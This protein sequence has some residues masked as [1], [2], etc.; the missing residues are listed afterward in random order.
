MRVFLLL[1]AL[2]APVLSGAQCLQLSGYGAD[3]LAKAIA[4]KV[5]ALEAKVPAPKA[6]PTLMF[7]TTK[8]RDPDVSAAGRE[9]AGVRQALKDAGCFDGDR[10]TRSVMRYTDTNKLAFI[11]SETD[12]LIK[13]LHERINAVGYANIDPATVSELKVR[14][15][16]YVVVVSGRTKAIREKCAFRFKL[17]AD[18]D[19]HSVG[20]REVMVGI[21]EV[22]TN[23]DLP[24]KYLEFVQDVDAR[25]IVIKSKAPTPICL[26]TVDFTSQSNSWQQQVGCILPNGQ[27]VLKRP[28]NPSSRWKYREDISVS[29]DNSCDSFTA[30]RMQLSAIFGETNSD[31]GPTNTGLPQGAVL[32]QCGCWGPGGPYPFPAAQCASGMAV[33]LQCAGFCPAGGSPYGT[34]CR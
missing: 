10:V 9:S 11:S 15:V 27:A 28:A 1:I 30:E 26:G 16:N 25:R 5:A 18:F 20:T 29:P 7:V 24:D 21:S 17:A 13:K 4:A 3:T 14:D 34:Q 33:N 19:V 6:R 22:N 8:F 23:A 32:R 12:P 2:C 31:P